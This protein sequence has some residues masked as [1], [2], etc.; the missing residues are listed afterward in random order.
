MDLYD[1]I[2]ESLCF[3]CVPILLGCV[4]YIWGCV[5]GFKV[6]MTIA[7]LLL[8]GLTV[9]WIIVNR[10]AERE[11]RKYLHEEAEKYIKRITKKD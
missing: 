7:C 11:Y 6:C 8:A 3:V 4:F 10:I 5:E 1:R 2:F 9:Y